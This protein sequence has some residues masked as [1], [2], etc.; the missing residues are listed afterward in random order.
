M[1]GGSPG[2]DTPNSGAFG[3][4]G[5][6][7]AGTFGA[8]PTGTFG[9]SPTG[10]FG[11]SPTGTFGASP[12]GAFG[13]GPG[14]ALDFGGTH[15]GT[16]TYGAASSGSGSSSQGSRDEVPLDPAAL[17]LA[18][19]RYEVER[20]PAPGQW[21]A[22]DRYLGRRVVLRVDEED[23]GDEFWRQARVL[24]RLE[25][26]GL[27]QVHDVGVV[28]G[29][30]FYSLDPLEGES[31]DRLLTGPVAERPTLPNLLRAFLNACA[32]IQ[33]ANEE[34]IAHGR[35]HPSHVR[36]GSFGQVWV[37]GWELALVLPSASSEVKQ[38]LGPAPPL[39][40]GDQSLAPELR[41]GDPPTLLVDVF[42]LGLVLHWILGV[43]L[44][45]RSGSTLRAGDGPAPLRAIAGKALAADPDGRYYS[46]RALQED[47]R[48]FIDGRAV[49]AVSEGPLRA[50]LRLLRRYPLAA[51]VTAVL[52]ALIL[53]GSLVT[54][55]MVRRRASTALARQREAQLAREEAQ[56]AREQAL[57]RARQARAQAKRAELVREAGG[58]ITRALS[59]GGAG[60]FGEAERLIEGA[61]SG[62][63]ERA[64]RDGLRAQLHLARGRRLLYDPLQPRPDLALA[65]FTRL[66]ELRPRDPD[67]W[68]LLFLAARRLPGRGA[69]E[70]EQEAIRRLG[71]LGDPWEAL[72]EIERELPELEQSARRKS[73]L[74][75]PRLHRLEHVRGRIEELAQIAAVLPHVAQARTLRGRLG[76][77]A[78]GPGVGR[79]AKLL[80]DKGQEVSGGRGIK[81]IWRDLYWAILLDPSDPEP[82]AAYIPSF[83]RKWGSHAPSRHKGG[84]PLGALRE[85]CRSSRRPEPPLALATV[86]QG[87]GRYASTIPLLEDALA[88]PVSGAARHPEAR[89]HDRLRLA[90]ARARLARGQDPRLEVGGLDVPED[91][92]PLVQLLDAWQRALA[93][94]FSGASRSFQESLRWLRGEGS[95]A[96][97]S[98]FFND[99]L[100]F[101]TDRRIDSRPFLQLLGPMAGPPG[102]IQGNPVVGSLHLGLAVHL[103]AAGGDPRG[104]LQALRQAQGSLGWP[105]WG[106][107]DGLLTLTSARLFLRQQAQHPGPHLDALRVIAMVSMS[108]GS[109]N[110]ALSGPALA[111]ISERLRQLGLPRAARAFSAVEDPVRELSVPRIYTAHEVWDWQGLSEER[112]R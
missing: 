108:E 111:L 112:A 69:H 65:D 23:L 61:G 82:Y 10:T 25:H 106:Y 6:P 103:E 105:P 12:T 50:G 41:Q 74:R 80:D 72:A 17:G 21:E 55:V 76:I 19:E 101:V 77:V 45:D 84:W 79:R 9:A 3:G 39:D 91:Y 56:A 8:S 90:L 47:V 52:S 94:D 53:A 16:G 96:E 88:R 78:T 97:P 20:R 58:A 14:G 51:G 38:A 57:S 34:G 24:G 7:P 49:L 27:R 73:Y 46:V 107:K 22:R 43:R 99:L 89:L 63:E 13:P 93:G 30:T 68:L 15:A 31:L 83:F 11:A 62:P 33:H 26:A 86:L 36:L 109:G 71:A 75:P 5:R 102:A 100:R 28:Q 42:G 29:K 40:P 70:R 18:G 66:T 67:A 110:E 4:T 1:F 87:L 59:Q 48:R 44:P 95:L 54:L 37:T 98:V 35:L 81:E 64:L 85:I 32:V 2:G 92:A 104:E 60:A